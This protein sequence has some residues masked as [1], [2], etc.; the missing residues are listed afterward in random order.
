M[1]NSVL[2][3]KSPAPRR[4]TG[5]ELLVNKNSWNWPELNSGEHACQKPKDFTGPGGIWGTH[6][7]RALQISESVSVAFLGHSP[8]VTSG[9]GLPSE[10]CAQKLAHLATEDGQLGSVGQG[11]ERKGIT[12]VLQVCTAVIAFLTGGSAGPGRGDTLGVTS[13]WVS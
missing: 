1:I 11:G 3:F 6:R 2:Y 5:T 8:G 9:Q 12:P 10:T 4:V 13:G 7:E